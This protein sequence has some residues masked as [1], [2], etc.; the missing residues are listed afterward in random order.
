LPGGNQQ[1]R[2]CQCALAGD[3]LEHGPHALKPVTLPGE[4][5]SGIARADGI[6]R[7]RR[8]CAG[9]LAQ[10]LG[11]SEA[12]VIVRGGEGGGFC[13]Y[14]R[15]PQ[16]VVDREIGARGIRDRCLRLL[17]D[18]R[19]CRGKPEDIE[20]GHVIAEV[21]RNAGAGE[22]R[23]LRLDPRSQAGGQDVA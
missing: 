23:G 14:I 18:L 17:S 11:D 21:G 2:D 16:L 15:C 12:V 5:V 20:R 7:E 9:E 13:P 19:D 1:P 10:G 3:L 8:L 4:P 22:P 6:A